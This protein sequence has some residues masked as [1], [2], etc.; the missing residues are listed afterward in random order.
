MAQRRKPLLRIDLVTLFPEMFEGPMSLSIVGR[1]RE[2]GLLELGFVNP[3]Q[4]ATDRHKTVDDRP[5]GG[6]AGMVLQAEPFYQAIL[7]VK[8]PGSKVLLLSP[9]GRRF[10][11]AEA[12][13]L[14][15]EKHL[16]LLC[17]HY[18]GFDERLLDFVDAEI[19]IGD[20]VLTGGEIPAMAI[21]DA[22]T[23]LLPGV[24][25]KEDA[26]VEESFTGELLD[27]PQYTRPQVWRGRRTPEVLL[28]GDHAKIS[29]WREKAARMATQQK[30]PDRLK[31][32]V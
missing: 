22:L 28:S 6:G 8:K 32:K 11:Q 12:R 24:L 3:R 31:N 20:F 23:R 30:R 15:L 14:S 4:F 27:Y 26:A 5:F 10:E 1:A 29:A 17:G 9:Q 18:E 25:A 13:S 7:S 16:I 21:V 19:S 2:Q